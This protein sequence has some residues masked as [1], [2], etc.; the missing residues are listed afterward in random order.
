MDEDADLHARAKSPTDTVSLK[1]LQILES[2]GLAVDL[3]VCPGA[4]CGREGSVQQKFETHPQPQ[5]DVQ[6][7]GLIRNIPLV[8]R[9]LPVVSVECGE[10]CGR[11]ERGDRVDCAENS[12]S[13][14]LPNLHNVSDSPFHQQRQFSMISGSLSEDDNVDDKHMDN[15]DTVVHSSGTTHSS[16]Y[17]SNMLGHVSAGADTR[18]N[19]NLETD[20]AIVERTPVVSFATTGSSPRSKSTSLEYEGKSMNTYL[21]RLRHTQSLPRRRRIPS[22]DI[23]SEDEFTTP[24]A[25]TN[26][27]LNPQ[28]GYGT[29]GRKDSSRYGKRPSI[30]TQAGL[31][32]NTLAAGV[33][34]TGI[35]SGN[36]GADESVD[37]GSSLDVGTD[38]EP[39][40]DQ[41]VCG[42]D[43]EYIDDYENYNPANDLMTVFSG[44]TLVLLMVLTCYLNY[45]L[46]SPYLTPVLWGVFASFALKGFQTQ[47]VD[48]L[49]KYLLEEASDDKGLTD[50][51][52][53]RGGNV[54]GS[55]S[56]GES[57]IHYVIDWLITF[58]KDVLTFIE[59]IVI[60]V[61]D[62]FSKKNN[63]QRT[64]QNVLRHSSTGTLRKKGKSDT[65]A[66]AGV[67][68]CP[69][70]RSKSM[71]ITL[72][73]DVAS[74][75]ERLLNGDEVA[76][77]GVNE[78]G[79]ID[80]VSDVGNG[81]GEHASINARLVLGKP[82]IPYADAS[83]HSASES[84]TAG[85]LISSHSPSSVGLPVCAP[86]L[87]PISPKA[88][89]RLPSTPIRRV[90][91][92]IEHDTP[93]STPTPIRAD[94]RQRGTTPGTTTPGQSHRKCKRPSS[95][96]IEIRV[97]MD[98]E[99]AANMYFRLLFAFVTMYLIYLSLLVIELYY[100]FLAMVVVCVI[101]ALIVAI[102]VAL[103]LLYGVLWSRPTKRAWARANDYVNGWLTTIW[104]SG[105]CLVCSTIWPVL[106]RVGSQLKFHTQAAAR[107]NV[108][109]MATSIV[110][111]LIGFLS[112]AFTIFFTFH[113]MRE[114][115]IIVSQTM[116]MVDEAVKERGGLVGI[117]GGR[118]QVR[119][120]VQTGLETGKEFLDQIFGSNVAGEDKGIL[121][122]I[123]DGL[124]EVMNTPTFIGPVSNGK[125]YFDLSGD[126]IEQLLPATH[127]MVASLSSNRDV[128]FVTVR[129][130]V[131]EIISLF[132]KELRRMEWASFQSTIIHV[133]SWYK[134]ATAEIVETIFVSLGGMSAVLLRAFSVATS[135][136]VSWGIFMAVFYYLLSVPGD[137]VTIVL[138]VFPLHDHTKGKVSKAVTQSIQGVFVSTAKVFTYHVLF[139]WLTF[140]LYDLDFVYMSCLLSGVFAI[141]PFFSSWMVAVVGALQLLARGQTLS[142]LWLWLMHYSLVWF[143]DPAIY[144]EIPASHPYVTGMSIVMGLSRWNLQG[145][146][147]GPIIVCIPVIMYQL[148]MDAANHRK[149]AF[150]QK[151]AQSPRTPRT[152]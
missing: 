113:V 137:P 51:R 9:E 111:L 39:E 28:G 82:D 86:M 75:R 26:T 148:Y 45:V 57:W 10:D 146:L 8:G 70:P 123:V 98:D 119:D 49:N 135:F 46:L 133:I 38:E 91:E 117:L 52:K 62:L 95:P 81:G 35:G 105:V 23:G 118:R 100:V 64:N 126:S 14:G 115:Q 54:S 17:P 6:R 22:Y 44:N 136:M 84:D 31:L 108:Q 143:V 99:P 140:H 12:A 13:G 109:E 89:P 71:N 67:R 141:V 74:V 34:I 125:S 90:A 50:A 40:S 77:A 68:T 18:L 16:T 103:W 127:R 33:G 7:S 11:S 122:F 3:S 80:L 59:R 144:G 42:T 152:T 102:F 66:Q 131:S 151:Y 149:Q 37:A 145:A 93:I 85:L 73:E 58:F 32:L 47:V 56:A 96:G 24:L 36:V 78:C 48:L 134:A 65:L 124:S 88:T 112:M 69:Q 128:T 21:A 147:I 25:H 1:A 4:A 121:T 63:S 5:H 129:D 132:W 76:G 55:D 27:R 150:H 101:V 92:S 106:R 20:T 15:N 29:T 120:V 61:V 142:A 60:P 43:D 87:Q 19:T 130:S 94:G 110:I 79:A 97:E 138:G 104:S 2:N 107:E 30:S 83:V 72:K 116:Q 139:T 41:E 53:T 114:S